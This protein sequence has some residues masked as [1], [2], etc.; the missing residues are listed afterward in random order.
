MKRRRLIAA[1]AAAGVAAAGRGANAQVLDV[2]D[3]INK[4]GRQR[5]L[6]Q[7]MAK[8]YCAI[9]LGV[10]PDD[11]AGVLQ[12]SM[13]R[14]DRQ[15][16]ELKAYAPNADIRATYAAL[17]GR[18]ADYKALLVGARPERARAAGVLEQGTRVL[19]IAHR[20]TAQYEAVS[21]R[22]VGVLVNVAGRQRMLS[23][24]M[25]AYYLG[26]A[27]GV[28]AD[29]AARE[30]AQARDEFVAAHERLRNA[31]E[32]T[33]AVQAQLDLAGT[34][35]IFFTSALRNLRPGATTDAGTRAA[36]NVFTTSERILQ[37]MER[38]TDL[39][40]RMPQA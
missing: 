6:S 4:A 30:M 18:W 19:E 34:Q 16:V 11:A 36:T 37:V 15:L 5:M 33:P 25:A 1:V 10:A 21:G 40:A 14:F 29:A 17:E 9:G 39:Y 3:A 23:Q 38:V 12:Q 13:A 26:A 31:P 27:W 8:A 2:N 24:R 7:R 20:G 35:F 28:G 22:A 32:T